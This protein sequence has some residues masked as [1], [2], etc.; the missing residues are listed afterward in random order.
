MD[1]ILGQDAHV[2]LFV[3][4]ITPT[5]IDAENTL[6]QTYNDAIPALVEARAD[7]GKHIALVDLYTPIESTPNYKTVLLRGTSDSLLPADKGYK[8]MGD[9]WYGAVKSVLP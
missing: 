4:Q 2:F 8:L 6:V 1:T 9:V 5:T 3:A 7:A